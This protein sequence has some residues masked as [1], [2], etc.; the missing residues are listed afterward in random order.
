MSLHHGSKMRLS[1]TNSIRSSTCRGAFLVS[2]YHLL[3]FFIH[4]SICFLLDFWNVLKSR[5][6]WMDQEEEDSSEEASNDIRGRRR[7]KLAEGKAHLR[8]TIIS[9][10]LYV[11]VKTTVSMIFEI[12]SF[13]WFCQLSRWKQF[14]RAQK[15][16]QQM[17]AA[18][19][20]RQ[21]S[22]IDLKWNWSGD[23][24]IATYCNV[25]LLWGRCFSVPLIIR[26]WACF[27]R[28][29]VLSR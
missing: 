18:L 12:Y 26:L 13:V 10:K 11:V 23:Y 4:F 24:G 28:M 19:Q 16:E 8:E 9:R 22:F 21:E 15:R 27:L 2:C 7:G 6:L 14:A 29:T 25:F 17:A 1:N 5:F 20:K 3:S